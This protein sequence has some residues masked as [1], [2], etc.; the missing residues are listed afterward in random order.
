[1]YE[2]GLYLFRQLEIE[3]TRITL[4]DKWQWRSANQISDYSVH[5]LD[6]CNRDRLLL[7]TDVEKSLDELKR[8]GQFDVSLLEKLVAIEL[9]FI[10]GTPKFSYHHALGLIQQE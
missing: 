3:D 9:D 8:S 4:T 5:E 10:E 1:M 7:E 2:E 6:L